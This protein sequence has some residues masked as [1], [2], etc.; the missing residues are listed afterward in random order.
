VNPKILVTGA[1][2][3]IGNYV[4]SELL[5]Q[6]F[7]VIATSSNAENAQQK[8]WIHHV[9]YIPFDFRKFDE[10]FDY[11]SFFGTPDLVIHLAWEGLPNYNEAFHRE[12]NYPRHFR[13]LENLILHGLKDVTITGTCF[14]Y[15][16]KTGRLVETML[17]QPANSYAAAKDALRKDVEVLAASK[18]IAFKW[19]RL[20]YMYGRGQN[21]KS[22]FAQL[23]KAIN[24]KA[25]SFNMSPGEQVRDFL[26]VEEVA[27]HIVSIA[28]QKKVTG[29]I[30]CCSNRPV[31]VKE[32]VK[33][34][35]TQRGVSMNLNLGYYSY[36]SYEPMAFWGDNNKLNLIKNE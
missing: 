29:I 25:A 7:Q 2:G 6:R 9:T 35:L 33:E 21:P 18:N 13:F 12:E 30:N 17:P 20:F 14:E 31:T 24:E 34:Y 28:S 15:G 4:V 36:A 16:M 26:P 11:Y 32:F 22:L 23:D 27:A 19:I 1:T 3:F 8:S 5:K 10:H